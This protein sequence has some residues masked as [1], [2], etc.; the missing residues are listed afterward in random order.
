MTPVITEANSAE[1]MEAAAQATQKYPGGHEG[2]GIVICGGGAKYF[3]CAYVCVRMLREVGCTL[4]VELWHLGP[5]EMDSEMRDLIA[6]LGVTCVDALQ[7]RDRHPV[8]TLGG[9]QLKPY[10]ILHSRFREALLLDADNFPLVDPSFL[11]ETPQYQRD[12]AIFWPDYGRLEYWRDIWRL[13]GVA[14][15]DEPEFESGQVVVDKAR[16]W[17]PLQLAMWMNEHSDFWYSHIWGDKDTFHLAW[18]KLGAPYSMPPYPI[19]SLSGV[20]CQ[21]DF[22]GRRIFQ[23][24]N[25]GKWSLYGH[26]PRI[27]GFLHEDKGLAF[28]D[29]LRQ[30][31]HTRADR[32]YCP[33]AASDEQRRIAEALCGGRWLYRRIGFDERPM[34]FGPD[35][36]VQEGAAACEETW[37]LEAAD[38]RHQLRIAGSGERTCLL[39][40]HPD[41]DGVDGWHG[42]WLVH[43]GME[44]ELRPHALIS[45]ASSSE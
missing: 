24:R 15:Q 14:Y 12:G 43:E 2:S 10:A 27:P 41:G 37:N 6:P 29:E 17:R 7:V 35:G 33:A 20:M 42:R 32:P 18:R 39:S 34:T 38:G 26:N 40:N 44:V 16:C 31:W 8:R 45:P 9:Y 30:C 21:H 5:A 13:A 3:T 22:Q 19:E 28:L 1:A 25:F 11:F 23:H 4:P 36:L